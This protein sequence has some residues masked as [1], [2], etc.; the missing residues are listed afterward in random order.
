MSYGP[1][2]ATTVEVQRPRDLARVADRGAVTELQLGHDSRPQDWSAEPELSDFTSLELLVVWASRVETANFIGGLDLRSLYLS[3]KNTLADITQLRSQR[4][5]EALVLDS[6][7]LEE[8][9][10]VRELPLQLL[11]ARNA[12]LREL[13]VLPLRTL[14]RLDVAGT[15]VKRLAERDA[16]E[17]EYLDLSRT[18]LVGLQGV[19][20]MP[21][22]RRILLSNAKRV[23]D[24]APLLKCQ[25]LNVVNLDKTAVEGEAVMRLLEGLP[26]LSLL[27]F[28]KTPAAES[29]LVPQ[30]RELA[31]RR[32]VTLGLKKW[33]FAIGYGI[34]T[35]DMEYF[36]RIYRGDENPRRHVSAL[37][38][39]CSYRQFSGA[40]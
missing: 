40:G 33:D 36:L 29:P 12:R 18:P 25:N 9:R 7:R 19:E 11:T 5:L 32:R 35:R 1:R 22:L 6:K 3:G 10:P 21:E 28:A 17:L 4:R 27:S 39:A 13:D 24:V 38:Y 31:E 34:E 2:M 30:L 26:E 23:A 8:L 20:R 16:P 15:R 37:G 14:R